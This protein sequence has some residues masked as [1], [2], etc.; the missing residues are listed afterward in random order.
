V[1]ANREGGNFYTEHVLDQKLFDDFASNRVEV[2]VKIKAPNGTSVQPDYV[3][4]GSSGNGKIT[5]IGDA[6]SG[7]IELKD[8]IRGLVS[9]ATQTTNREL[10]FYTPTGRTPIPQE[11]KELANFN[12]VTIRQVK[13]PYE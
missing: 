8:Q 5:A 9:A 13:V 10:I 12:D 7:A 6:K 11:L 4:Y 3:F 1:R 2:Q